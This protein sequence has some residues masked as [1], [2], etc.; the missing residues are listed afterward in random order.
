MQSLQVS[1]TSGISLNTPGSAAARV[2]G[3]IFGLNRCVIIKGILH[4][5]LYPDAVMGRN[6]TVSLRSGVTRKE[7]VFQLGAGYRRVEG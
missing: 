7:T 5:R 6:P 3:T 1:G 4:P 2:R